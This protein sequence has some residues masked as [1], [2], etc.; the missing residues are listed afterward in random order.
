M[1]ITEQFITIFL[2]S[3]GTIITRSLPFLVFPEHKPIPKY[4]TYL[5]KVLAPSV[6][7]LLIVYSL[8]ETTVVKYSY[9]LPEILSVVFLLFLHIKKRNMLVSICFGTLFYM[10]LVQ[11]VFK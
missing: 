2:V 8:K 7:G 9:G 3:L 10:F 1:T 5:G 6:F 4:V 11:F